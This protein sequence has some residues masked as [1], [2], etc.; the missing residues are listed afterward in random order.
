MTTLQT[1]IAVIAAVALFLYA[2]QGFS[3]ELQV[4][5]GDTLREWLGRVTS[6]RWRAFAVGGV[7]TAV[8]QSSSAV[9]SLAVALVDAR[10]I[11]FGA[12]LAIML[13]AHVG[14]TATAWLVSFKLTGIGPLFIV[15]GTLLSMMPKRIAIFGKAAF[16]FGLVF[17]TLDLIGSELR[18]L[19]EHGML[20][21][22]LQL[23]Q[24]PILGILTG[25]VIT[26]LVQSSSVTTGLAI[27]LV[28]QGM[29]A[30][31][32]AIAIAMG[33]NIGTSTTALIASTAMKQSA[34]R[35]AVANLGFNLVGVTLFFPFIP[36]FAAAVIDASAS[37]GIAV[38]AAHLIFNVIV[39]TLFMLVLPRVEALL[40][41]RFTNDAE[42]E[43]INRHQT[44]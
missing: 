23:A 20:A 6:N 39:S 43:A 8:V 12:S 7:S 21:E 14:T 22:W 4:A 28:Q 37:P 19:R 26:A 3:R 35:A 25:I 41:E 36:A 27:V 29:L 31:E 2:L 30:P 34:R 32:A 9:T 18:P 44:P 13:G 24:V 38:A 1:I 5:G 10:V 11:T 33:A 42:V 17:F 40:A 15:L 16:Y